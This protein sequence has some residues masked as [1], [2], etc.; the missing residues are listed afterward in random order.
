MKVALLK[1]K[2]TD[3]NRLLALAAEELETGMR[4]LL[5]DVADEKTLVAKVLEEAFNNLRQARR[6][7]AELERM[8]E[9]ASA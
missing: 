8:L 5:S 6:D 1:A 3:A 2:L 7:V 4:G 9:E